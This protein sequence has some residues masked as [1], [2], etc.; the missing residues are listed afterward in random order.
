MPDLGAANAA[1]AAIRGAIELVQRVKE[2]ELRSQL[3]DRILEL[4][5]HLLDLQET[6]ASLREEKRS[7][8]ERVSIGEMTMKDGMLWDG[9]DG[10]FCPSCA[11]GDDRKVRVSKNPAN[12]WYVCDVCQ[13][14]PV[15]APR[16]PGWG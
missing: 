15:G 4:Q 14:S 5:A 8:L 11:Q 9:E 16:P 2:S 6:I 13:R 3:Q 7:L 12:G 10:P 1:I